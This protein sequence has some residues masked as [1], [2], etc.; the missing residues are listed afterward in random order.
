L[1]P[2]RAPLL[3]ID[4]A[5]MSTARTGIENYLH[6]LLPGLVA[7]WRAA[8]GEVVVFATDTAVVAHIQPP[9]QVDAGGGPG[10]TQARL[11]VRARRLGLDVYFSPIPVLPVLAGVGCPCVV[12][13]HD[14][15]EFRSRW[16]YFRRLIG[17]TL[18]R[19]AA[20]VC[21]SQATLEDLR[22]EFPAAAART[23]VVREAADQSLY[24]EPEAGEPTSPPV[25]QRLGLAEPP[26]LAVGT[27]QPRKN[28]VR[29]IEAYARIA[30][31]AA[32]APPLVIVGGMGWDIAEVMARPAAL[33]IQ[34]RV[35]FAGHLEEE[36][37]AQLMRHS[38]LLAAVS[39]A[40]GFGLPLVEAMCSGIAILASDIPPFREVAGH[41]AT[42][43][44]PTS[45]EDITAGLRRL[46]GDEGLRVQLVEV[47]R[48]RRS[49]FSWDRAG[50]EVS[51]VLRG[52]LTGV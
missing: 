39:T 28:Y 4:A 22:T 30:G 26:L 51:A 25:F 34:D 15:L 7:S 1:K 49:L 3:G 21:V 20:V 36:E 10:W 17:R 37:L 6:H 52:A 27:I 12:T 44:N 16:W 38:L 29:L 33:G 18:G 19:A 47:A 31:D 14:L 42:F 43:V 46:L 11:P 45:V 41:A 8:G 9:V 5:R 48:A 35:V 40:E 23:V 2:T 32:P 13:V 50:A 24:H